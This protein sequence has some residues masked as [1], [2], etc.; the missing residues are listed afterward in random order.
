MRAAL[1]VGTE[2]L[3]DVVAG[4]KG[5]VF[6]DGLRLCREESMAMRSVGGGTGVWAADGV[7]IRPAL[8]RDAIR[9]LPSCGVAVAMGWLWIL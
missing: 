4:M 7:F 2:G 8:V 3:P 1:V 5:T 9:S 6:W